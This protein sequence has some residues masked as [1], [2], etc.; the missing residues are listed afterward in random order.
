MTKVILFDLD[1][2]LTDSA[3]GMVK[4]IKYM[5]DHYGI[6]HPDDETFRTFFGP[7][8]ADMCQQHFGMDEEQSQAAV[9]KYRERYNDIGLFEN[10]VYPG[11]REVL[12]TLVALDDKPV[13]AVA[14]SK[15]TVA[16]TRILEHFDLAKYFDFI[17][18]AAQDRSRD[19][20]AL[21]IE[22]TLAAL[23]VDPKRA[24]I[25]MVGDREHDVKGAAA[26]GIPTIGVLWGYGSEHELKAAGAVMT[27][28]TPAQLGRV[29]LAQ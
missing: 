2:T 4:S 26:H 20:K 28:P 13:L 10:D 3:P 19:T 5:L 8:L 6:E 12:D 15:P 27:V 24:D 18:G 11:I 7:P 9:W 16:S 14:T 23:D 1:G 17:G 21:V 29:L 25:V 22:H